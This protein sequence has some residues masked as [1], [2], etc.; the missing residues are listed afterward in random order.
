MENHATQQLLAQVSDDLGNLPEEDLALVAAF[1]TYL[2]QRH[3]PP[4]S[5]MAAAAIRAEARRRAEALSET[6]R[7]EL[8]ARFQQLA[9]EVRTQAV[10]E[11]SA[12]EGDW[13]RD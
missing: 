13:E 7:A 5:Q 10:A 2:K 8:V 4:V 1:V 9:E 12:V 6:P 3:N 11:G